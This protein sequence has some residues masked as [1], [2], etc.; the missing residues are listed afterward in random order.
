[1]ISSIQTRDLPFQ[2]K[3][4]VAGIFRKTPAG[5]AAA[6]RRARAVKG[7]AIAL[8]AIRRS[9]IVRSSHFQMI[10]NLSLGRLQGCPMDLTPVF[11]SGRRT[12]SSS[13]FLV[14]LSCGIA[15]VNDTG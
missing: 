7:N 1:L 6:P 8:P 9:L 5:A 10:I 4:F 2:N 11:A 15:F 13:A 14:R 12:Y 3:G